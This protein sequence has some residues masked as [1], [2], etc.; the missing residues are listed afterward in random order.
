MSFLDHRSPSQPDKNYFCCIKVPK[1]VAR[2][3]RISLSGFF[4][5]DTDDLQ[6]SRGREGTIV[7]PLDY[8]HPFTNIQTNIWNFALSYETT[9]A[10]KCIACIYQNI[11]KYL[12][13]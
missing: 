1:T 13:R 6:G 5:T 11:P 8:F 7:I 10:F 4:F 2:V 3:I 12:E 9:I